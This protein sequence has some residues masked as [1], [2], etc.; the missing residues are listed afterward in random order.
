MHVQIYIDKYTLRSELLTEETSHLSRQKRVN[1]D[2]DP[3]TE[4]PYIVQIYFDNTEITK[5]LCGGVIIGLMHILTAAQCLHQDEGS[6]KFCL[7]STPLTKTI[8][9]YIKPSFSKVYHAR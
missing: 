4:S 7:L 8:D 1:E 5:F 3:N 6:V 9:I 2:I